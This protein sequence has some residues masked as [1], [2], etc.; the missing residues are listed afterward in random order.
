MPI[1]T[2]DVLAAMPALTRRLPCD[3]FEVFELGGREFIPVVVR[4]FVRA[5][6]VVV[7]AA[8]ADEVLVAGFE[9]LEALDFGAVV[10][11]RFVEALAGFVADDG[12]IFAGGGG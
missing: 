2:L 11:E 7:A 9:L 4:A 3:D 5:V 6:G 1:Y 12:G 8:D 10:V